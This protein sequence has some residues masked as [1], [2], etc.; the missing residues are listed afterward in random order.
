MTLPV[1]GPMTAAMINLELGRAGTAQFSINGADERG[2]A[3]IPSGPISFSDFY[4]KSAG[5]LGKGSGLPW[6]AFSTCTGEV[7]VTQYVASSIITLW[8]YGRTNRFTSGNMIGVPGDSVELKSWYEPQTPAIGD[9]YWARIINLVATRDIGVPFSITTASG[10]TILGY[11]TK[12]W[13]FSAAPGVWTQLNAGFVVR[14]YIEVP[15]SGA[16]TLHESDI[17]LSGALEFAASP[18]GTVLYT[19]PFYLRSETYGV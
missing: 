2:L 6:Q 4:G 3:G 11:Y 7:D 13:E 12:F 5:G 18:G 16:I 9:G 17:T 15:G 10:S 1:S 19:E 14:T 8:S